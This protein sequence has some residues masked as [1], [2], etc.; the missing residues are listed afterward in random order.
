MPNHS[1]IHAEIIAKTFKT[2]KAHIPV[3]PPRI[4]SLLANPHHDIDSLHPHLP[5]ASST[6]VLLPIPNLQTT[7]DYP[8]PTSLIPGTTTTIDTSPPHWSLLIISVIDNL[9]IHYT[10]HPATNPSKTDLASRPGSHASST[11]GIARVVARRLGEALNK[12]FVFQ[13]AQI[14][15]RASFGSDCGLETCALMKYLLVERL[16]TAQQNRTVMMGIAHLEG[17]ME[18]MVARQREEMGR[19]VEKRL[20][21]KAKGGRTGPDAPVPVKRNSI[22]GML[23]GRRFVW[24]GAGS[25]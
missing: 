14:N 25:P 5:D 12:R 2:T 17:E 20:G 16:L 4:V 8:L 1:W 23:F 6:H 7:L 24:G 21:G 9:A 18:G 19:E 10:L 3:L 15:Y 22:F 11:G 13:T